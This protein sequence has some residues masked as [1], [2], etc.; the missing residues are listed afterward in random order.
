MLVIVVVVV[1]V[2]YLA[3]GALVDDR[4]G[5]A[6]IVAREHLG[7]LARDASSQSVN[8][9]Q[10]IQVVFAIGAS[11]Q[12][13][14]PMERPQRR[15]DRVLAAVT[16]PHVLQLPEPP[17][18]VPAVTYRDF[19]RFFQVFKALVYSGIISSVGGGGMCAAA[20][21][22][23]VYFC[24]TRTLWWTCS[25]VRG[26]RAAHR[27]EHHHRDHV[28][29]C[30]DGGARAFEVVVRCRL[31]EV[32]R[33]QPRVDSFQSRLCLL[34]LLIFLGRVY[35]RHQQSGGGCG[36]QER[37]TDRRGP[38][39][40]AGRGAARTAAATGSGRIAA[41]G[42]TAAPDTVVD[43]LLLC[44]LLLLLLG[45]LSV[46]SSPPPPRGH[47]LDAGLLLVVVAGS[48]PPRRRRRRRL[49]YNY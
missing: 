44:L 11:G 28:G 46:P 34:L 9:Q 21:A 41:G 30:V 32:A 45:D 2:V 19:V 33:V 47:W 20:A 42:R 49:C 13:S 36:H 35:S 23:A 38:V 10:G 1:V 40:P 17:A 48:A 7:E 12:H 3:I 4:I 37:R 16:Q 27:R 8:L 26:S 6:A 31:D 15:D 5:L 25:I 43:E 22:A 18:T 29:R 24:I 14:L 39:H